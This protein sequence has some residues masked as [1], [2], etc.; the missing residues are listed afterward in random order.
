MHLCTL[1]SKGVFISKFL[2]SILPS[3]SS[4]IYATGNSRPATTIEFRRSSYTGDL[5]TLHLRLPFFFPLFPVDKQR[6]TSRSA[7]TAT[8]EG[9]AAMGGISGVAGQRRTPASS[10]GQQR[11]ATLAASLS[12]VHRKEQRTT[13]AF[14]H[15]RNKQTRKTSSACN[16]RR[17]RR[18]DCVQRAHLL[19]I[20]AKCTFFIV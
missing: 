16:V 15:V 13:T 3:L 5:I 17:F 6:K 19:A 11:W 18:T 20:G 7:S 4:S 1:L 10:G 8:G 12:P 9:A 14:S 2:I